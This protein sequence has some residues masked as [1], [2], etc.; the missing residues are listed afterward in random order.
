MER[1]SRCVIPNW[2]QDIS[3]RSILPPPHGRDSESSTYSIKRLTTEHGKSDSNGEAMGCW[4]HIEQLPQEP[5]NGVA[6]DVAGDSQGRI[7]SVVRD[8][9]ADGTFNGI[10]PATGHIRVFDQAG[11]V[12]ETRTL[13]GMLVGGVRRGRR[14]RTLHEVAARCVHRR[15]RVTLYHRDWR[16]RSTA[17][18]RRV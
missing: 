14:R 15:R 5:V 17:E 1:T 16:E 4:G 3:C 11:A 9:K 7:Y 8:P 10:T 2:I 6:A 12:I 13:D 18:I